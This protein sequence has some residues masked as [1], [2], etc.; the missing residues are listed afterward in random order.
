MSVSPTQ[1]PEGSQPPANPVA[2]AAGSGMDETILSSSPSP[3]KR[4]WRGLFR[5]VWRGVNN[6]L[7]D[8]VVVMGSDNVYLASRE[9]PEPASYAAFVA[10]SKVNGKVIAMGDKARAMVGREPQN[11]EVIRLL[12]HG[13]PDNPAMFGDFLQAVVKKHFKHLPF[14]RPRVLVSGN[15]HTPLMK[16]VCTEGL[17]RIRTRDVMFCEPEVAAAVGLGLDIL[18]PDLQ[19]VMVFEKDWL[20]FMVISMSGSLTRLRMQLGFHD[21]LEDILIFFEEAG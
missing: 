11:I 7:D 6:V 13:I 3:P 19:T 10:R 14:L 15:F 20:G 21:L 16:Q 12:T 18:K 4:D 17:L 8:I 5:M 2:A 9:L 1:E